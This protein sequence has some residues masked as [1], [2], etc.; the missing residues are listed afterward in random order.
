MSLR[1]C[2]LVWFGLV[3]WAFLFFGRCKYR[4]VYLFDDERFI[5]GV[6]R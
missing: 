5:S 1:I 3:L 2:G 6:V 4:Y